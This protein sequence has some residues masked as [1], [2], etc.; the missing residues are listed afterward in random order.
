M[1]CLPRSFGGTA[2]VSPYRYI[3]MES[4]LRSRLKKMMGVKGVFKMCLSEKDTSLSLAVDIIISNFVEGGRLECKSAVPVIDDANRLRRKLTMK[5]IRN[6][7]LI[8][9]MIQDKSEVKMAPFPVMSH[10]NTRIDLT[11][12]A[13]EYSRREVFEDQQQL[14]QAT[15]EL[16]LFERTLMRGRKN[17]LFS[18]RIDNLRQTPKVIN[19]KTKQGFGIKF[20]SVYSGDIL[21]HTITSVE[22]Q[23]KPGVWR[24]YVSV[25]DRHLVRQDLKKTF[26]VRDDVQWFDMFDKTRVNSTI[27][28][29][30]GHYFLCGT[31]TDNERV[32]FPLIYLCFAAPTSRFK[33]TL[34]LNPDGKFIA[35]KQE[36]E[37][38]GCLDDS[39]FSFD[40]Q[41]FYEISEKYEEPQL[42]EPDEILLPDDGI[43]LNDEISDSSESDESEDESESVAS[44]FNS[45]RVSADYVKNFASD[46]NFRRD[47]GGASWS[48]YLPI[49]LRVSD[50]YWEDEISPLENLIRMAEDLEQD[51]TM[52]IKF[53]FKIACIK[54]RDFQSY[55]R[56]AL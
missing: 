18:I 43:D 12:F 49:K 17:N 50:F 47:R 52:W 10:G 4:T 2:D 37:A 20:E 16:K 31:E 21:S 48:L 3:S 28:D 15:Q 41:K 54:S 53:A 46:T 19:Y 13:N 27:W 30:N 35:K 6:P 56:V 36:L 32:K 39:D 51:E 14:V 40:T 11:W 1:T 25:Y 29:I 44:S 5:Q 42:T 34:H 23:S 55:K 24:K 7:E 22:Q 38:L 8:K 9:G 33:V 26:D 45:S